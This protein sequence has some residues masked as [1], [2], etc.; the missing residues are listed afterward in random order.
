MVLGLSIWNNCG[1]L[2]KEFTVS[3]KN[4][5][6]C[7]STEVILFQLSAVRTK[8]SDAVQGGGPQA[9]RQGV[10]LEEEQLRLAAA[11]EEEGEE[12]RGTTHILGVC[13]VCQRH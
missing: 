10:L 3:H 12:D 13:P 8:D 11:G 6:E 7:V 2:T 9:L 1:T 5:T 4:N